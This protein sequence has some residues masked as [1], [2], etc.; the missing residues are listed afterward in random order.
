MRLAKKSISLLLILSLLAGMFSVLSISANA[1]SSFLELNTPVGSTAESYETQTWYFTPETDGRY[2]FK[3]DSDVDGESQINVYD[4]YGYYVDNGWGG[5]V[6]KLDNVYLYEGEQYSVEIA[7]YPWDY[8][9]NIDYSLVV[10]E[11]QSVKAIE[12]QP[13]KEAIE[14]VE[15]TGGTWEYNDNGYY[16]Y[17]KGFS[18]GDVINLTFEDGS[19]DSF[20][21]YLDEGVWLNSVEEELDRYVWLDGDQYEKPW[22]PDGDNYVRVG[23]DDTYSNKIPVTIIKNE[24][25]ITAIEYQPLEVMSFT[26]YEG[27]YEDYSYY[28]YSTENYHS[29]GFCTGDKLIAVLRNGTRLTYTYRE[30][31]GWCGYSEDM[32]FEPVVRF[33]DSQNS[34]NPWEIGEKN[35]YWIQA[36][37]FVSNKINA[38]IKENPKAPI[39]VT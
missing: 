19:H 20:T 32:R 3:A 14:Y 6:V 23:V 39:A 16:Y 15:Q 37:G 12:Y 21:Y 34:N 10:S 18:D 13:K 7:F 31:V 5:T 38:V 4:S 29:G 8:Q 24:N 35:E 11:Y 25:A 36:G 28:R 9:E 26:E 33:Y 30:Q 17:S 2:C 22:V 1:A 27:G